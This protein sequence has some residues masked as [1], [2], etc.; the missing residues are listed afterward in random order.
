MNEHD[1]KDAPTAD[2]DEYSKRFLTVPLPADHPVVRALDAAE[3]VWGSSQYDSAAA[4]Y[5]NL[6]RQEK[7]YGRDKL[8][9]EYDIKVGPVVLFEGEVLREFK[10]PLFAGL[11]EWEA[12]NENIDWLRT[13]LEDV[14]TVTDALHFL[15]DWSWDLWSGAPYMVPWVFPE[16][17]LDNVPDAPGSGPVLNVMAQGEN[18]RVGII[19]YLLK[20]YNFV[21]DDEPFKEWDT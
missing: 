15:R 14:K 16:L 11:V 1:S 21:T 6:C 19:C 9:T 10:K 5:M 12:D 13:K 20:S 8:L 3:F 4:T 7:K 17:N 2:E 18:T